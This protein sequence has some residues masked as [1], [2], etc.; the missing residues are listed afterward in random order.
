MGGGPATAAPCRRTCA[1][2]LAFVA[3]DSGRPH[4]RRQ[5]GQG[6]RARRARGL[7]RRGARAPARAGAVERAHRRHR[8]G[9]AAARRSAVL[10]VRAAFAGAWPWPP[11]TTA[12]T[13]AAPTAS[14]ASPSGSAALAARTPLERAVLG[15]D[16]ESAGRAHAPAGGGRRARA[17]CR[18]VTGRRHR[19]GRPAGRPRRRARD[20]VLV[21]VGNG[22]TIC[23]VALE[24]RLAG[25]Y[26]DHTYRA[27]RRRAS[28]STC[29]ASW[30][31]TGRATR[32]A[33]GRPRRGAGRPAARP[34]CPPACRS[35]SP[36]RTATCS[37]AARCP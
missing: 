31:A 2:G 26:E 25:V 11:R 17:P 9:R 37:P 21:N 20:A 27:R 36:V 14:C 6:D 35:S 15:R 29:G 32:C 22:H 5:P 3:T 1:A 16:A 10:G 28:S 13:R 34:A 30:P 4:L 7:R 18:Q 19:P 8:P 24:G 12:S 33:R 23:A